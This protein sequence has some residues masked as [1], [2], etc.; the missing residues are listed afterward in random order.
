MRRLLF[1]L[2]ASSFV[3]LLACE[4]SDPPEGPQAI[5]VEGW[6]SEYDAPVE[7]FIVVL[8]Y[9]LELQVT[10]DH[11]GRFRFEDVVPPYDILVLEPGW[12]DNYVL[13]GF[14]GLTHP[15]PRLP[16]RE[17]LRSADLSGFVTGVEHPRFG[18]TELMLGLS[19][20]EASTVHPI[21]VGTDRIEF[22]RISWQG[23]ATYSGTVV[24]VSVDVSDEQA[25][26]FVS[27]GASAHFEVED[28]GTAAVDLAIDTPVETQVTQ[29]VVQTGAY[30]NETYVDVASFEIFDAIFPGYPLAVVRGS[31]IHLPT[32]GASL[33]LIAADSE[34]HM[35][36]TVVPATLGGE[37]VLS[38]P[39]TPPL[40]VVRPERDAIVTTRTPILEW[41]E[42]PGARVYEVTL[43]GPDL[44]AT[45]LVPAGTT[46]LQVPS[47]EPFLQFA[48][49]ETYSW[50]VAADTG[51]NLSPQ[52]LVD[53][54]GP[55][56]NPTWW[57]HALDGY[58]V[59]ADFEV[60]AD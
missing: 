24:G 3:L 30:T 37:T 31:E 21:F 13:R 50:G 12:D 45:W 10:T 6:V 51:V 11:D 5:T 27:A 22:Q 35:A 54:D 29:V 44:D 42:V 7:G 55:G 34:G 41:T 49:G 38:L 18:E 57:L 52:E 47:L 59:G 17:D 60:A 53:P 9:D 8:N 28:G 14:H 25:P 4:G 19:G 48:P 56:A 15:N 1:T 46:Q 20:V 23:P 33:R 26:H 43:Y 40:R 58:F 16:L 36:A 39:D 32:A 2:F